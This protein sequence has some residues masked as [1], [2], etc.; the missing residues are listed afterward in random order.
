MGVWP[1]SPCILYQT[2][3]R[4]YQANKDVYI[5]TYSDQQKCNLFIHFFLFSELFCP[6][7]DSLA[8]PQ[9]PSA[10]LGNCFQL[11]FI[12]QLRFLLLG[13]LSLSRLAFTHQGNFFFIR[14][15]LLAISFHL[16]DQVSP[17]RLTFTCY[18]TFHMLSQTFTHQARIL[19]LGQFSLVSLV[20]LC[21]LSFCSLGQ[22]SF[23]I[24]V[25]IARF[26]LLCRLSL[27]RWIFLH[28]SYFFLTRS[29]S[30]A[31]PVFSHYV[32]FLSL[33]LF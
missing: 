17:T 15:L 32:S 1:K 12:L 10:G 30:L 14:Q 11:A 5:N 26:L 23:A 6:V 7:Q 33:D 2:Q 27:T 25:L 19:L 20:F 13:Q 24:S 22:L 8:F 28:K 21:Y 4:F 3:N 9:L 31:K 16:L 18:I 29:L